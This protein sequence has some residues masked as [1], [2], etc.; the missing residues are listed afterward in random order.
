MNKIA[1]YFDYAAA[2]PLL[3]GAQKAMEPY[4]SSEF[5]NP[6][7]LYLKARQNR[8]ALESARSTIAQGLGAKPLEVI[9]TAGGT[10]ANNLA[11]RGV[12][13]NHPQAKVL[14]SAIEHESVLAPANPYDCQQLP[15]DDKGIVKIDDLKKALT[16]EVV[17]ISVMY[18]NNEIGA[19]QPIREIS[20]IIKLANKS[21]QNRGVK[22]L[23]FHSDACQAVNYLDMQVDKLGVDLMT[24]NA[25]KIYGPK[26]CG[27]L[28][29]RSGL[30][31]QPLILGGG[32][33]QG[34][35]SGTQN[36]ANIVGFAKAWQIIRQDYQKEAKRLG[37]LCD[38]FI[39]DTKEHIPEVVINGPVG[40][41]RLANNIS[42][43]VKG[44]DNERLV[45]MLDEL[46]F[47]VATGS[48]C[49]AASDEP[50]HVLRALGKTDDESRSTI[51]ITLGRYTTTKSLNDLAR[52][53]E[54]LAKK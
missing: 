43:S 19:I 37:E 6:S 49:S 17:L 4:F 7:A 40:H 52:A 34:W 41:S 22:P 11:I 53:L 3:L 48:A 12:L 10:E 24:I 25:G 14:V 45:M 39:A 27:A 20:Q 29:V 42:L 21:R 46:G 15:V 28:Y 26:Q 44:V 47:Q 8:L 54:K 16:D 50:S 9:F 13:A 31:L 1:N 30:V 36:L 35:R 18:A 32:Q 38:K 23:L 2:T 5:Y 33:E 51:R